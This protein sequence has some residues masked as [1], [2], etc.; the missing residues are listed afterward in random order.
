[1]IRFL[2][3]ST[4]TCFVSRL[5]QIVG[6]PAL[7]PGKIFER[8]AHGLDRGNIAPDLIE[9]MRDRELKTGRSH[10]YR[11]LNSIRMR[12]RESQRNAATE[13]IAHHRHL[14]YAKPVEQGGNLVDPDLLVFDPALGIGIAKPEHVRRNDAKRSEEH[15]S[16]LQSLMRISYAVF[17]L[18]KKKT[19]DKHAEVDNKEQREQTA[20]IT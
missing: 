1:M 8:R 10:Q 19:Q 18:I 11:P 5:D 17:C 16:E 15:T 12:D 7:I 14:V 13:R 3:T 20:A 4:H 6:Q 9:R 2:C